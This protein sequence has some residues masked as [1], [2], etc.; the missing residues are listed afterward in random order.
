MC[1][2]RIN[3]VDMDKLSIDDVDIFYHTLSE[4]QAAKKRAQKKQAERE[5]RR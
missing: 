4:Y 1:E 3:V 2:D 5:S